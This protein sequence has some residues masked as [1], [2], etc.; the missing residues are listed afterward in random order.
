MRRPVLL[1]LAVAIVAASFSSIFVRLSEAP[2]LVLSFYRMVLALPF[3]AAALVLGGWTA[4]GRGA[5][6]GRGAASRGADA[7]REASVRREAAGRGTATKRRDLLLVIVSGI[8][9]AL[10]FATW[11]ASLRYTTVASSLVLVCS[12]PLIV[13]AASLV[14]RE[15]RL[16]PG[17]YAAGGLALVGVILVGGGDYTLGGTALYGD[18]LAFLG[19]IFVAGYMLIGRRVRAR[20]DNASYTLGVYLA[21]AVALGVIG[22]VGR[23]P[24]LGYPPRE[25]LLFLALAVVS[26]LFGHSLF[27]WA[28]GHVPAAV[29][30]V[31]T[32]A[33]PAIAS[34]LAWLIFGEVP[35]APEFVG[36]VVILGGLFWFGLAMQ[37]EPR[38]SAVA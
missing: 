1:V 23:V 5:D 36:G 37:S 11:M 20:L 12:N 13:A 25:W 30:S 2:A 15:E 14:M 28:L 33:E 16:P 34:A 31:G 4:A 26:T 29:V 6:A 8:C 10:H 21:A 19:A 32:L 18:A 35:T 27:N 9:L 17:A 38:G 22:V 7:G 3:T 24:L